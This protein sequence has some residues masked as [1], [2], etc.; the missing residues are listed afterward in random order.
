ME[1]NV[2]GTSV[3]IHPRE[4]DVAGGFLTMVESV[5]NGNKNFGIHGVLHAWCV[6]TFGEDIED[7][8]EFVNHTVCKLM[9]SLIMKG[10]K[11]QLTIPPRK[12]VPIYKMV[13]MDEW[14]DVT[15]RKAKNTIKE[16]CD[17][18]NLPPHNYIFNSPQS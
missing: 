10:H 4:L 12:I 3:C 14:W 5:N 7:E 9:L 17:L 6:T 13:M 18:F 1:L 2:D 11:K 8:P 15:N 16:V